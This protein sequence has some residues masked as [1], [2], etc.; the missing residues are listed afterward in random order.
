M[1]NFN[2]H[3]SKKRIIYP[4]FLILVALLTIGCSNERADF[5]STIDLQLEERLIFQLDTRRLVIQLED[6]PS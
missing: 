4:L 6:G 1:I 3:Y 5:V 2:R